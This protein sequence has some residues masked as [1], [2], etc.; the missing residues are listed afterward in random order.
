MA[1]E[2]LQRA[3]SYSM[4]SFVLSSMLAVGLGL[5]VAEI[6]AP[7][8]NGRLVSLALFANFVVMPAGALV[9]A[10][11]LRLDEPLGAALVLLGSAAGAP[12]LPKLAG[13]ARG[14]L[15]LAVGLT[16]LLMVLTVAYMPLALPLL[17]AGVTVDPM[18]IARSLVLLMLVPLAVAL[19][20]RARWEGVARAA[21]PW[22]GK[23]SS[24]SLALLMVG[25]IATNF[26]NLLDLYG[27]RGVFAS[28][29]F[30]ALGVVAGWLLGGRDR[31]TKG[32]MALGTAQRNIAAALVV[33]GQSFTDPR[34]VVLVVVVA[35]VGMLMLFPLARFL[36]AA[37][38]RADGARA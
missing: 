35:I 20:V 8:R 11:L 38:P 6:L 18:E 24:A 28:V 19:F 25:M 12:F 4:F 17:L 34:V 5:T 10:R 2:I 15:G 21:R 32:M 29:V 31:G 3:V 23:L 27:T 14:D 13:I 1:M 37:Q 33:A 36:A 16:V 7:L 26:Q 9:I 30:L 22:L